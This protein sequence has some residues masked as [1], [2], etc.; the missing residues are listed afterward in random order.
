MR[1]AEDRNYIATLPAAERRAALAIMLLTRLRD[2]MDWFNDRGKTQKSTAKR[3]E[4][5]ERAQAL[6][7]LYIASLEMAV[8]SPTLGASLVRQPGRGT[9]RALVGATNGLLLC[10]A[11]MA[12]YEAGDPGFGCSACRFDNPG[13]LITF[14]LTPG[15]DVFRKPWGG[16]ANFKL[17]LPE[18]GGSWDSEGWY[19]NGTLREGGAELGLLGPATPLSDL[20]PFTWTAPDG[21]VPSDADRPRFAQALPAWMTALPRVDDRTLA[22]HEGENPFGGWGFSSYLREDRWALSPEAIL[23]E[24]EDLFVADP[25]SHQYH[26]LIA[27]LLPLACPPKAP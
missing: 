18:L 5:A 3:R 2:Q 14:G 4:L 26:L 9:L 27:G 12:R 20:E 19:P 15:L 24:L 16:L 25:S 8:V 22:T 1:L 7:R 13:L 17:R 21:R 23:A 6:D 11:C 10:D